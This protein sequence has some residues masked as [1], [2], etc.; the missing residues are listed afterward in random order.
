L[1]MCP[2]SYATEKLVFDQFMPNSSPHSTEPYGITNK[3]ITRIYTPS[4]F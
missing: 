3:L 2:L 1:G 4:A